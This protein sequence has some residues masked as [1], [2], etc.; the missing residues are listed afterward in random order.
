MFIYPNEL[1]EKNQPTHRYEIYERNL[2][3]LKFWLKGDE[4]P[5]PDKAEQY[6]RWRELRK[7][8]EKTPAFAP[9]ANL[10]H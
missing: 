2:D 1:H 10:S 6:K 5:N 7:L 9:Q 3:W 4:D 8:Q